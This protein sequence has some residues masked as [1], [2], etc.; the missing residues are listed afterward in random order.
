MSACDWYA[1]ELMHT[2]EMYD[3]TNFAMKRYTIYKVNWLISA[4]NSACVTVVP[5]KK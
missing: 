4:W 1:K 2:S 3:S 5:G